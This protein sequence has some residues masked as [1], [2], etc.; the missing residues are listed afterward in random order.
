[1]NK[2]PIGHKVYYH[3]DTRGRREG[4]VADPNLYVPSRRSDHK[5]NPSVVWGLWGDSPTATY[6]MAHR[7]HSDEP[8]PELVPVGT[9]VVFSVDEE[10]PLTMSEDDFNSYYKDVKNVVVLAKVTWAQGQGL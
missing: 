5:D 9:I 4:V 1:V 8:V 3:C 10:P 2:F 7:V 6:V